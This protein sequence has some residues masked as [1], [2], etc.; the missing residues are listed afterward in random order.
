MT[1]REI[2]L[3]AKQLVFVFMLT[4]VAAVTVFLLGVWVGRGINVD[5]SLAGPAAS[6]AGTVASAR[7]TK[8]EPG[9]LTYP[10]LLQGSG[11]STPPIR[12]APEPPPP[13]PPPATEK[14]APPAAAP[15]K[16][17]AAAATQKPAPADADGWMV[18]TSAYS[19]KANADR[20]AAALKAKGY[21]AFVAS[22][23]PPFR[24]RVGPYPDK[25]AASKVATR[26]QAETKD[27]PSVIP[28]R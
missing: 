14:D 6:D 2:Q 10:D 3:T 5:S 15:E 23:G 17:K 11:A 9:K 21:P 24:V 13:S 19:S 1:T 7:D 16:A 22:G 18:Q 26:L 20:Q 28:P 4:L 25:A 8:A 12:P 27:K